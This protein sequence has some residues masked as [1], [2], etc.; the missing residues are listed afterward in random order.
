MQQAQHRVVCVRKVR[1]REGEGRT[2][3]SKTQYVLRMI[4]LWLGFA[5]FVAWICYYAWTLMAPAE[6]Q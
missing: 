6:W 3:V 2:S 5:M 1:Q 4:A